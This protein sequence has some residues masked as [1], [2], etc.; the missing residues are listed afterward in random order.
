MSES[1]TTGGDTWALFSHHIKEGQTFTPVIDHILSF[2]DLEL[3]QF[4]IP[5][6]LELEIYYC[7]AWHHPTG[8]PQSAATMHFPITWPWEG[9]KRVRFTMS[10]FL[11]RAGTEYAIVLYEHLPAVFGAIAWLYD[12]D[13]ATYPRGYRISKPG[14]LLDWQTHAADDHIFTEFGNPPLPKPEP[15][16]PV[17][18]FAPLQIKYSLKPIGLVITL[19]TSV[20]CHLTCYYTDIKPRKHHTARVVRGLEVPWAT[21]FC[22]VA[23]KEVEQNEPGDTLYHSFTFSEW[24]T[25]TI[26]R[27]EWDLTLGNYPPYWEPWGATLTENHP[28]EQAFLPDLVQYSLTDGVL[29]LFNPDTPKAGIRCTIHHGDMPLVSPS[30]APL[31]FNAYTPSHTIDKPTNWIAYHLLATFELEQLHLEFVIDHG[32]AWPRIPGYRFTGD[33]TAI[34][35]YYDNPGPVNVVDFWKWGRQQLGKSVDPAGWDIFLTYEILERDPPPTNIDL[36]NDYFNL[37]YPT[38]KTTIAHGNERYFTF[39]GVVDEIQSPSVG[40]IFSL[41]HPGATLTSIILRPN[42]PG[43]WCGL[44]HGCTPCPNHYLC[45]DDIIPDEGATWVRGQTRPP[46]IRPADLY[47]IEAPTLTL[48]IIHSI[49]ITIR[50]RGVVSPTAASSGGKTNAGTF[51]GPLHTLDHIWRDYTDTWT[52]NPITGN[53]WTWPEINDLQIGLRLVRTAA[54]LGWAYCT[55]TYVTVNYWS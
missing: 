53:P 38:K 9:S 41:C 12:K 14:E 28:W 51:L 54:G 30:G 43:D 46:D 19:S 48:P 18:H 23:W 25:C 2:V 47:N 27:T 5:V 11:L 3:D 37:F 33:N 6:T 20:P 21:Y 15:T 40:P 29:H 17:G 55:Q 50:S 24:P 4:W 49:D 31:C 34:Y 10:P 52:T 32:N 42:A 22:F 8:I 7:D 16:P 26:V 1:Y 45:V 13:D 36:Y 39:R 44:P 35:G